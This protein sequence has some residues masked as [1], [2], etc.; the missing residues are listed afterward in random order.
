MTVNFFL[1]E[2]LQVFVPFPSTASVKDIKADLLVKKIIGAE[3][4]KEIS[5]EC[6]AGV[7][8]AP[9]PIPLMVYSLVLALEHSSREQATFRSGIVA[10]PAL[11][12]YKN[13]QRQPLVSS[14]AIP[15]STFYQPTGAVYQPT[16]AVY[17]P[18]GPDYQAAG[19]VSYSAPQGAVVYSAGAPGFVK[20]NV[21]KNLYTRF[22]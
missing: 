20:T 6:V 18:A 19:A 21:N 8:Q 11:E 16:G 12:F 4:L 2:Q 1:A 17:Q 5:Q 7:R 13:L 15:F 14:F 10:N 9:Q 22:Y 3:A